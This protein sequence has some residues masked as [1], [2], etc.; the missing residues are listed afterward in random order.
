MSTT[1]HFIDSTNVS[2]PPD[3]DNNVS[4]ENHNSTLTPS[5]FNEVLVTTSN[6]FYNRGY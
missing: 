3:F 1:D 6:W 5:Q 2:L 4:E